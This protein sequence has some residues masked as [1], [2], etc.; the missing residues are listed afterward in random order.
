VCICMYVHTYTRRVLSDSLRLLV[1]KAWPWGEEPATINRETR[2]RLRTTTL[3][4]VPT[5]QY[6]DVTRR[7]VPASRTRW[8]KPRAIGPPF[9]LGSQNRDQ[10][11]H[12]LSSR[13]NRDSFSILSPF[14]PGNDGGGKSP[15]Q[16][17][18]PRL[19]APL[20]GPAV[21]REPGKTKPQCQ[22]SKVRQNTIT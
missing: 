18:R 10:I 21:A 13:C 5:K 14:H 4:Y 22:L 8:I 11:M 2:E 1:R 3:L 6:V 20:S 16:A 17:A 15:T 12:P 19:D 7:S 9:Y